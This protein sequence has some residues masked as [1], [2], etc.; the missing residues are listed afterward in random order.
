[1]P[2]VV[3]E[4]DDGFKACKKGTRR[5]YSK[6]PLTKAKAE[7]Q[8]RALYASETGD[9]TG[10]GFFD[11]AKKIY[12]KGK[13]VAQSAAKTIFA[14]PQ[15]ATAVAAA[16]TAEGPTTQ[17][18]QD[19][20]PMAGLPNNNI[21]QQMASAAYK[22]ENA[23]PAIAG[24]ELLK[25]TPFLKFWRN[26][27]TIM[28]GVRGTADAADAVADAKIAGGQLET[29]Q[30]W[31]S[32][33]ATVEQ[34]QQ[35]YPQSEYNY[36]ATGHS[37]GGA[38]VDLLLKYKFVKQGVSWNPAVQTAFY[39]APNHKRIYISEDPLY[40]LMGKY[41]TRNVEVR[42]RKK[43]GEIEQALSGISGELGSLAGTFNAH[44]IAQFEG[45]KMKVLP[46][47]Q[48][49]KVV[50]TRKH[51]L[52]PKG[53]VNVNRKHIKGSGVEED[54]ALSRA[55]NK[56]RY[57][58]KD[59]DDSSE[60]LRTATEPENSLAYKL[61]L[62]DFKAATKALQQ[63][64]EEVKRAESAAAAKPEAEPSE[65]E[66]MQAR[67]AARV[68]DVP[69]MPAE[70]IR[71]AKASVSG[72]RQRVEEEEPAPAPTPAPEPSAKKARTEEEPVKEE[73]KEITPSTQSRFDKANIDAIV[74]PYEIA[75]PQTIPQKRKAQVPAIIRKIAKAVNG[76]EKCIQKV[77]TAEDETALDYVKSDKKIVQIVLLA[78]HPDKNP[79]CI[80]E[81][82]KRFAD[83]R[84][85]SK[86]SGMS[87]GFL[88]AAM[89]AVGLLKGA[90]DR[91]MSWADKK[92]QELLEERLNDNYETLMN[93]YKQLASKFQRVGQ[94]PFVWANT[95]DNLYIFQNPYNGNR[96]F[97]RDQQ[98]ANGLAK[99]AY[100]DFDKEVTRASNENT[101]P[102]RPQQ[103]NQVFKLALIPNW[104]YD[105]EAVGG[106]YHKDYQEAIAPY[107][108]PDY[109]L[110]NFA[111]S[112]SE[113][114]MQA[115]YDKAVQPL[116][117][118]LQKSE[119]TW[120]DYKQQMQAQRVAM[121]KQTGSTAY[122]QPGDPGYVGKGGCC[123]GSACCAACALGK[124]CTGNGRLVY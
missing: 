15:G 47:P 69:T 46:F 98:R 5:C 109:W 22:P 61:K 86:G 56:M 39:D 10:A 14:S 90:W 112:A 104:V 103:T 34:F 123:G 121:A 78:L 83:Y 96:Y 24:W 93:N 87:G 21:L 71:A 23:V 18:T 68:R 4:E 105:Y 17:G 116:K 95:A 32:D 97:L 30:R 1:M 91:T 76:G 25:A 2:Y 82:Q 117:A 19:F 92:E 13:E 88:P 54:R 3:R 53:A 59:Y 41:V 44:G 45:G 107:E 79:D 31:L 52:N 42:Q 120:G 26:G 20:S 8:L 80:S 38:L 81:A 49:Y 12:S 67:E 72:K 94:Y 62:R 7:A 122:L 115:V 65:W 114:E 33:K 29:D 63:A 113:E 111:P 106:K 64:E 28:I 60:E 108:N 50:T 102:E 84:K 35:Q 36:Y 77:I 119:E 110:Q 101:L 66:R 85:R 55:Q 70:D 74:K 75:N 37:L 51:K 124:P 89:A 11:W 58:Q 73:Y 48:A 40:N 99:K 57:A 16:P 100:L 43:K 9:M 27:N 6:K 118:R